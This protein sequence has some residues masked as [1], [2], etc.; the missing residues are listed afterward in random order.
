MTT[1]T[2]TTKKI[3]I[4]DYVPTA[5]QLRAFLADVPD[6]ARVTIRS[7]DS[8][9]EGSSTTITAVWEPSPPL[10]EIYY[11]GGTR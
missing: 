3:T 1:T 2:V 7:T 5:G 10:H 8:Q 11:R 9:R 4:D 6:A